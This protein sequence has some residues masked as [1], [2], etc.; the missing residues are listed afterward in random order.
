MAGLYN[1]M[2]LGFFHYQGKWDFKNKL[3]LYN[4]TVFFLF[5]CCVACT[6]MYL[7]EPLV[8]K[9]CVEL[10]KLLLYAR[11]PPQAVH[12]WPWS[13]THMK[14]LWHRSFQCSMQQFFKMSSVSTNNHD[15]ACQNP[16]ALCV[17]PTLFGVWAWPSIISRPSLYI[18]EL[19]AN[20]H[21]LPY[22][23]E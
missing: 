9:T 20:P 3:S 5:C 14:L 11:W 6:Y 17:Q 4:S 23:L 8:V 21:Q 1:F 13:Y 10:H 7:H 18:I 15:H 19:T 22:F 2:R 16:L 12:L